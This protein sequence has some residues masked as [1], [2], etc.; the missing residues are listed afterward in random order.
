M[1]PW[2]GVILYIDKGG[3]FTFWKVGGGGTLVKWISSSEKHPWIK[4]KGGG[5][6]GGVKFCLS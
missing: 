3:G 1:V 4:I 5:Q 6:E 2:W